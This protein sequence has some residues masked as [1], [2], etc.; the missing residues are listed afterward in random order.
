MHVDNIQL[1]PSEEVVITGDLNVDLLIE[2]NHRLNEIMYN[3]NL[4][5]CIN[6]PTRFGAFLDPIIYSDE[7]EI[8]FSYVIQINP[9]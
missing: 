5:N 1:G 3:F 2:I 6:E 9:Y 7:C 4:R 8:S